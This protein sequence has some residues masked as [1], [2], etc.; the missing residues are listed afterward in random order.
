MTS[1]RGTTVNR[2]CKR[3]KRALGSISIYLYVCVC[4]RI[5]GCCGDRARRCGARSP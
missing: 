4:E 1:Q 3:A 2:I 5:G